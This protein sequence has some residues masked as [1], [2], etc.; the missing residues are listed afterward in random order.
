MYN[1]L[2]FPATTFCTH[3]PP[4]PTLRSIFFILSF[5]PL[6]LGDISVKILLHGISEI[7]LPMFSSRTFLVLWL[8]FKSFIHI[9]LIFVYGV[10]WWSSLILLHVAVQ[11]SQH[12]LLKRLFWFHFIETWVYFWA[13]YSVPLIYVS[14]LMPVPGCFDYCGLVI[15]FD[16]RYCDPS[17][18][19]LLSQ[20]CCSYSR[21]VSYTH[22]TLPTTIG[23]CRSRWS[24]YH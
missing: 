23:W 14:V 17:Y 12:H 10:R 15:L 22:L 5:I 21:S 7:F 9:E 3:P 6:A 8:I 13:L 18:F 20:N 2:H 16:V 11:I 1:C 4:T 19:V 24:P